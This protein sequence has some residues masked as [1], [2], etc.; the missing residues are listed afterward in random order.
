MIETHIN[1][2]ESAHPQASLFPVAEALPAA[3]DAVTARTAPITAKRLTRAQFARQERVAKSTVTRWVQDGRITLGPDGL[4]DAAAAAVERLATES[5]LAQHQTRKAQFIAERE[6]TD[7]PRTTDAATG[8][9]AAPDA[10][11]APSAP[12]DSAVIG[13]SLKYETYRLQKAKAELANLDIDK[14]AG[15]LVER[16]EIDFI[17]SDYGATVRDQ[18]ESLPDRLTPDLSACRGDPSA[19]HKTLAD[20]ARQALD[21]IDQHLLRRLAALS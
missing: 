11:P 21:T 18:F 4:I 12:S 17:L 1:A 9:P 2:P 3:T 5:P 7:Q 14:A 19:L 16:A 20:A 13:A 10:P 6:A 8:Q 15:L